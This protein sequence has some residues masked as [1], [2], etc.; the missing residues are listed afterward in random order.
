MELG[1]ETNISQM[2]FRKTLNFTDSTI[3]LQG[4]TTEN[5]VANLNEAV[6]LDDPSKKW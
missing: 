2:N 1:K 3:S 6:L 5:D 4:N